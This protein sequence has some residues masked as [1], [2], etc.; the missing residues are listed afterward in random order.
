VRLLLGLLSAVIAAAGA[1]A[2]PAVVR[3]QVGADGLL[4]PAAVTIKSGDTIEW[5]FTSRR[6]AVVAA[7]SEAA[8]TNACPVPRAFDARNP[9]AFAGPV[10]FAPGGV[11]SLAPLE[12]RGLQLVRGPCPGGRSQASTNGQTL[13]NN[14]PALTTME[15]TWADPNNTGVFIRLL[16]NMV[17]IAPGTADSSFNFQDLDREVSQAVR[18]GKL[19]SLAIK[20]GHLMGEMAARNGEQIPAVDVQQAL[21]RVLNPNHK[22]GQTL[23]PEF[24]QIQCEKCARMCSQTANYCPRCGTTILKTRVAGRGTHICPKC[25][26]L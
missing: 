9:A 16:W 23:L 6:Q 13:C 19:Y 24:R 10:S 4:S 18:H 2:A 20:A 21:A 25:Q 15:D 14:G 3:V 17:Q 22:P 11:F 1:L 5:T 26:Q 12:D 7:L 8:A